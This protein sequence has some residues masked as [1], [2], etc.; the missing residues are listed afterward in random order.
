MPWGLNLSYSVGDTNENVQQ[1]RSLFFGN[2]GISLSSIATQTQMHSNKVLRISAPGHFENNDAFITNEKNIFL[3][4]TIADC[5]P[6]FLF[7]AKKNVIASIHSGWRGTINGIVQST[8]ALMNKEFLSLPKNIYCFIGVGAG[9]C[10][11][12]VQN[13]VASQFEPKYLVQNDATHYFL[14]LQACIKNILMKGGIPEDNIETTSHCTIHQ[15]DLFHS[16]RREGNR[17]G[18]MVGVI[19]MKS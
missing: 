2:L 19:G 1:N 5:Y 14:D 16:Y 12:E 10:C 8:L 7:D 4:V 11:Y 3:C 17:S 15:P 9:K 6:V 18:R 13:D